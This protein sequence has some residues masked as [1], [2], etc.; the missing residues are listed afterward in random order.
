MCRVY[1]LFLPCA[2]RAGRVPLEVERKVRC[3]QTLDV[4]D[5]VQERCEPHRLVPLSHLTYLLQRTGR[6]RPALRPGR[7]LLARV[8]FGQTVSLHP[9]RPQS[10]RLVRRLRRY[11]RPVRRPVVVH[12]RRV[13][14]DF[15]VRPLTPSVRGNQIL[16]DLRRL[17]QSGRIPSL[18]VYLDS[19]MAIQATVMYAPHRG[20]R[21][22]AEAGTIHRRAPVR[23]A[24]LPSL[25]QRGGVRAPQ[26]HG[27]TRDHPGRQRHGHGR[28][29]SP[30][31][32]APPTRS[33]DHGALRR[34]SGRRHA[35]PAA[36]GGRAR[37]KDAGRGGPGT[38][39]DHGE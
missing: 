28:A 26:R 24:A 13:S 23:A 27:W 30:S 33:A 21:H 9:L 16:Y 6:A 32:Q 29:H 5:V 3:P 22:R 12:H 2:G 18:P 31:P 17:E 39:P 37:D 10:P 11:Y 1:K 4:G 19:P 25:A 35:R 36:E 20:A 8:P 38:C 7:V 15:P 14:L 34:L